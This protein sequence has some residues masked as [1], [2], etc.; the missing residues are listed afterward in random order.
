MHSRKLE[1]WLQITGLFGV[2]GSLM[3]VGLQMRQDREIALAEMWQARTAAVAEYAASMAGN[4]MVMSAYAEIAD[5]VFGIDTTEEQAALYAI[6]AAMYLWENSHYQY[7]RGFLPEEHWTRIQANLR[8]N[9]GNSFWRP[10]IL[11]L[12]PQMTPSF[13]AAV[14]ELAD[15]VDVESE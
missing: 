1:D 11:L 12:A 10:K 5:P 3:F 14:E 15:E 7:E 6:W 4:E 13:R 9:L 8:L 2:I